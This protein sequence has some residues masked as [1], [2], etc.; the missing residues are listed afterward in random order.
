MENNNEKLDELNISCDI[1]NREN[2]V[3]SINEKLDREKNKEILS[4]DKNNISRIVEN[5]VSITKDDDGNYMEKVKKSESYVDSII[6][7]AGITSYNL[8]VYLIIALFFLADG[9][10]MI[11]IS[12]LVSKLGHKWQLDHFEKGF[13]GAGVFIGFFFG[14]LLS[15]KISDSK[16]RKPA[17]ITGATIVCI[18]AILSSLSPSYYFLVLCRCC[19]GLGL[20]L[21]VPAATALATEITPTNLRAWVLSLIWLFFPV[22]EMLAVIIAENV[23]Y[24]YENGWRVMLGCIGIPSLIN[25]CVSY[26]I[27][28]SP[29]YFLTMKQYAKAF[30]S[31][32]IIRIS[33][34]K[35]KLSTEEK[36]IIISQSN[37][38]G[39]ENDIKVQ[40][41]FSNL[42]DKEYFTLTFR[43]CGIFFCC[44]FIYYGLVY[45]LPQ[46]IENE[47]TKNGLNNTAFNNNQTTQHHELVNNTAAQ[48][49]MFTGIL[50]SAVSEIP[51]IFVASCLS[52]IESLGRIRSMVIGFMLSGLFSMLCA[53]YVGFLGLFASCLKFAISISFGVIYIYTCEAYPTKIRSIAIGVS[54]SATRLAGVLTPLISQMLFSMSDTLPY[55]AFG[56]TSII[57]IIFTFWLPFETYG[58]EIE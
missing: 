44:S 56:I 17:F 45:I 43:I 37:A 21:S 39:D 13:I 2:S 6:N 3:Y 36:E 15:G 34:N 47:S 51:S 53:L 58:K 22:G 55:T 11:V 29:R 40:V 9:G 42:L 23:L 32:D 30:D 31:L 10:E 19:S 20:G 26:F 27:H 1:V 8:R 16:G 35:H 33:N 7:N 28:E 12:L 4:N 50:F 25:C 5:S 52:N 18:F 14:A 41:G 57:G 48:T 49:R 46:G 38:E 54:N 24:Q